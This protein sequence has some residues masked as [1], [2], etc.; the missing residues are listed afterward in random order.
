MYTGR[1]LWAALEAATDLCNSGPP[2]WRTERLA[3]PAQLQAFLDQAGIHPP[4]PITER[5]VAAAHRLRRQLREVFAADDEQIAVERLNTLVDQA[6]LRPRLQRHERSWRW[7]AAPPPDAPPTGFL[8]ART[9]VALLSLIA[10]DGIQ[11]L[12]GCAA[13]GCHGVFV[14][15]T[16]NRSRR[17][18]IP[19]LCGN[20]TNLAAYRARRR[21]RRLASP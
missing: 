10:Q 19:E 6:G 1:E 7:G 18:C 14:D 11:R 15:A 8:V 20:R 13:D 21:A 4:Q 5:D 12:H 2:V 9:A 16:R 17:Y 3:S